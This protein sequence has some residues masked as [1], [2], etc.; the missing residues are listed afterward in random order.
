MRVLFLPEYFLPHV[1]GGEV[2]CWNVARNLAKRH[3]VTV[4]TY[5]HPERRMSE[6]V[7]KVNIIRVGPFPISGVQPYFT[8]ASIQVPFSLIHSMKRKFDVVLASQ[9]LPLPLGKMISLLRRKPIVSIFHDVYGLEFSLRDKGIVKGMIRG[10]LEAFSLKLGY[11]AVI[12]VSDSVKEKLIGWGVPGDRVH[13]VYGGV[14]IRAF[15][16]IEGRKSEKPVILYVGRLVR[17]KRV[18]LLIKSFEEVIKSFPEAVLWIAGDGPERAHLEGMARDRNLPVRFLGWISEEEKIRA[19]KM[20]WCL[21]FP[22]E[23]EGL[24]L[25]LLESMACRT[26]VVA[27]N[28]G[29]PKAV[30][31]DGVNGF[32]IPPGDVNALSDRILRIL[33]DEDLRD[34]MGGA[35][36]RVVEEKFTWEKVAER[37]E[38]VLLSVLNE[39]K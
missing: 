27:V 3:E 1:G 26:P 2:W 23:K 6:V 20:A 34:S 18:D 10:S 36:R 28:S 19:M 37:V 38:K 16:D 35:G 12:T 39:T 4:L 7:D 30:V 9:T 29:G 22:S 5:K 24:G 14:D 31:K 15:D 11:D 13:V 32:L 21:A 25:V 8:R 17:H 33:S